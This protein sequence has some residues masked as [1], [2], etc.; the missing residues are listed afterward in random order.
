MD[1][2]ISREAALDKLNMAYRLCTRYV[3]RLFLELGIV[4][5]KGLPAADVE[6]VRHAKWKSIGAER[7]RFGLWKCTGTDG[8]GKVT[9][10]KSNYCPNCGAKMD[11]ENGNG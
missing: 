10:Y 4:C 7:G 3:E 11:M 1:D 2:Y 5:V 6:P 9:P 8:C